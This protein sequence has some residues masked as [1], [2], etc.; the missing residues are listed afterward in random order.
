M[1]IFGISCFYNDSAAVLVVDAGYLNKLCKLSA[2]SEVAKDIQ[3][4][5]IMANPVCPALNLN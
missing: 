1:R 2:A 3:P 5:G 4:N